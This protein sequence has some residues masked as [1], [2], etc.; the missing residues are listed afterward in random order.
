M[1]KRTKISL[2][3]K[4]YLTIVGLLALT[5]I[6]YAATPVTFSTFQG[7]TGLAASKTEL[8]A[9]GFISPETNVYTF[10]PLLC[11]GIPLV[12]QQAPGGEKYVAIAPAQAQAAGFTPRDVF[13]TLGDFIV[14]ATPPGPFALFATVA[15]SG[16]VQD[17]TGTT[18]DKVG[19]FGHNMIVTCQEG[20]VFLIDGNGAVLNGGLPIADFVA[21][22]GLQAGAQE[23]GAR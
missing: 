2:R 17:H 1:K 15:C 3:T 22:L 8:F 5:G 11:D 18:F 23:A 16:N 4:I 12:Y 7:L 9:T 20:E 21:R 14:K 19:T 6:I 13:V 10:S